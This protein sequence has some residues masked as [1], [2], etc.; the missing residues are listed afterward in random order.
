MPEVH[1]ESRKTHHEHN[2]FL[3]VNYYQNFW[4]SQLSKKI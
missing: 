4:N 2:I 1:K 3:G